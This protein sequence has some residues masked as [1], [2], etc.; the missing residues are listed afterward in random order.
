[1]QVIDPL[2][3][4]SPITRST[5]RLILFEALN[6]ETLNVSSAVFCRERL[7][8]WNSVLWRR[9]RRGHPALALARVGAEQDGLG[10]R[11]QCHAESA[12][13]CGDTMT[14]PYPTTTR[15]TAAERMRR[16]RERRQDGLRCLT[17]ELR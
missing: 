4:F 6:S 16:H 7:T 5:L 13:T 8:P 12:Q 1:V 15:S 2:E 9:Q 17:I 14:A 11:N 10:E 3:L